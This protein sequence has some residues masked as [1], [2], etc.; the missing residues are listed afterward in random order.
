MICDM[1]STAPDWVIE[2]PETEQVFNELGI[3]TSCGGKS[4]LY[5]CAHRG[6]DPDVVLARLQ[7]VVER[8][9][10]QCDDREAHDRNG[11]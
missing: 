7:A 6:L 4:L 10:H 11:Q 2:Y 3:D 1:D 9:Q 8:V 5:L